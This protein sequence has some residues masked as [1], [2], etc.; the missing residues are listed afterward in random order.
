M[1]AKHGL[2]LFIETDNH[3]LLF[4]TGPDGSFHQNA[5]DLGIDLSE[6]DMLIISHAHYDHGGGLEEFFKI[7]KHAPVYLGLHAQDEYYSRRSENE[8]QYIGLKQSLLEANSHRIRYIA[9][10]ISIAEH[11]IL[12]P[13]S[14]HST[15]KP[16]A[17]L[18]MM[19]NGVLAEDTYEHELLMVIEEEGVLHVFTGCSHNGVENMIL[20]VHKEFPGM[21]IQTLIGGF[22]LMNFHT[23][24][25]V[26][27]EETVKDL[28]RNLLA[29]DIIKFYTCHCTGTE[30]MKVL[31]KVMGERI[32]W[33]S[34]G[35][36]LKTVL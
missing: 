22:H 35:T 30:A 21:Q 2:S 11:I 4:D 1:I 19:H 10:K 26:E 32:E 5:Q 6:V 34:T 36:V 28:A 12:L 7:N 25:M 16:S 31:Q 9:E 18:Y 14:E 20:T 29:R 24:K 15:F 3:K 27:D 8:L 23:G 17:I 13:N 33:V